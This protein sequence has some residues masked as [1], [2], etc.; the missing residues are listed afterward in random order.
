[1]EATATRARGS[2]GEAMGVAGARHGGEAM[3]GT[4]AR[5]CEELATQ[6][7]EDLLARIGEKIVFPM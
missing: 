7:E 1:M 2:G 3:S 4:A 6:K 5:P